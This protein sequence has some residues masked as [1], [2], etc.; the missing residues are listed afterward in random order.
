MAI[1]AVVIGAVVIFWPQ[2]SAIA[3]GTAEENANAS[4]PVPED[5]P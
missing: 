3:F 4:V 2:I 5:T 1:A